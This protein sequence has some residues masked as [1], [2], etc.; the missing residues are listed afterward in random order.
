MKEPSNHLEQAIEDH[1]T[2]TQGPPREL[3]LSE[4]SLK[5]KASCNDFSTGRETP[6]KSAKRISQTPIF[7]SQETT[8]A[9]SYLSKLIPDSLAISNSMVPI[10]HDKILITSDLSPTLLNFDH[11]PY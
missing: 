11:M 7:S 6:I 8:S 1:T 3:P 2:N 4:P 9:S 5:R 10:C